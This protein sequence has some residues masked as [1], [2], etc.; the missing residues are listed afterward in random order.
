MQAETTSRGRRGRLRWFA[1]VVGVALLAY[2][3]S[4]IGVGIIIDNLKAVGWG[5]V[6]I[7]ALGGIFHLVRACA[8]RLTFRSDVRGLSI[9]RLFGLRLISEAAGTFGLAGQMVGD[10]MRVS[11]LGPTIP[12]DD[13]ISSVALDRAA[14]IV[15]SGA[16]GVTGTVAAVLLLSL[17]G[18]WRIY[19]V[20]FA[21]TLTLVLVL[22]LVSFAS[23]WH[24]CSYLMHPG[25]RL[26]WARK[27]LAQRASVI[28]ASEENLLS[29]RSR[30]PRS[31]WTLIALYFASQTL[32]I[33]E[34][35]LLLRFMGVGIMPVGAFVVESFTKLVNVVGALN[36]GNVGT[37][38]GG[39]LLVARMLGFPA[40]AGLTL[41]LCRRARILF[42]AAIGAV[43]LT[44]WPRHTS[45]DVP[46]TPGG[47][48][49][50]YT[51]NGIEPEY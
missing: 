42:W 9:A 48:N 11:L 23:G 21:G 49:T 41:A 46:I 26:P 34:V 19:A 6:L 8:W 5:M 12:M 39:N 50:A 35:Y 40:A 14:Y 37:Y 51:F 15:S 45:R 33:A 24:I 22:A 1:V 28:E 2:L 13:R 25:Q 38:E 43:C 10:G 4:R 30:A 32:A 18:L 27:W 36:P 20:A 7:L 16:V 3:V 29:F 17:E 31:F 47:A 44:A